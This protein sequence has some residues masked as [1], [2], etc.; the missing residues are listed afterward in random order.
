MHQRR[1]ADGHLLK[2][3]ERLD[4]QAARILRG[5]G[6]HRD[7]HQTASKRGECLRRGMVGNAQADA[8]IGAMKR[9]Q[10]GQKEAV[11]R[12]LARADG[13]HAALQAAVA[14]QL[15]LARLNLLAGDGNAR[16]QL[17]A[18]R[19]ERHAAVAAHKERAAQRGFQIADRPG[20]V[21]LAGKQ[22]PGGFGEAAEPRDGVK[23]AVR[24]IA[25]DHGMPPCVFD[26]E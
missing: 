13:N 19:R 26:M 17:F 21:G 1:A 8:R 14:G 15:L 2:L 20:E 12:C 4:M 22:R 9:A 7:V 16:E 6:D 3:P 11:Q 18:L 23:D 24:V 5:R 25:D 10:H